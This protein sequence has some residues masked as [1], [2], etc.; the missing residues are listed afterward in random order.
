MVK[1]KIKNGGERKWLALSHQSWLI[2]LSFIVIAAGSFLYQTISRQVQAADATVYQGS[3]TSKILP[4][5]S[6]SESDKQL[7]A[8]N[9]LEIAGDNLPNHAVFY[10]QAY[11]G[12]GH[13]LLPD[14]TPSNEATFLTL[15]GSDYWV[16]QVRFVQ[17]KIELNGTADDQPRVRSI[18]LHYAVESTTSA[19]TD[20]TLIVEPSANQSVVPSTGQP[21]VVAGQ[22]VV[23][24]ASV[25][26]ESAYQGNVNLE[27]DGNLPAGVASVNGLPV[28]LNVTRAAQPFTVQT[29]A[30]PGEID[31]PLRAKAAAAGIPDQTVTLKIYVVT[32][33][34]NISAPISS[35]VWPN[36]Q[37]HNIVWDNAATCSLGTATIEYKLLD[38]TNWQNI[39]SSEVNDGSYTWNIPGSLLGQIQVRIIIGG[40]GLTPPPSAMSQLFLISESIPIPIITIVAPTASATW[41]GGTTQAIK[42]QINTAAIQHVKLEYRQNSNSSWVLIADNQASSQTGTNNYNW[43]VPNV[44]STSVQIRITDDANIGTTSISDQF[45]IQKAPAG[46]IT[47]NL[48]MPLEE[49]Y[50]GTR[51]YNLTFAFYLAATSSNSLLFSQANNSITGGGDS[52]QDSISLP[53]N[54]SLTNGQSYTVFVK[55][56]RHLTASTDFIFQDSTTTYN[57]TFPKLFAGDLD[58]NDD[59]GALDFAIFENSYGQTGNDLLADMDNNGLVNVFDALYILNNFF[60]SGPLKNSSW[61]A[62]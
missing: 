32:Q 50:A 56:P 22:S 24:S 44:S 47:L 14:F 16:A 46:N 52:S 36:S 51:H 42:W 62:G 60:K 19:G 11:D 4:L 17:F 1:R 10:I 29:T 34:F 41:L 3:Y 33:T 58:G 40:T 18:L 12:A 39:T 30:S 48:S 45:T 28:I 54:L 2:L 55:T 57:L 5:F 49:N 59:I 13:P 15:T 8:F 31:L 20:F 25:S 26:P 37:S 27:V 35:T 6:D 7:V 53:T 38:S 21:V 43:L 23:Y 9:G 61:L